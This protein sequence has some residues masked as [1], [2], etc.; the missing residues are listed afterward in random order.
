MGV[1]IKPKENKRELKEGETERLKNTVE[2]PETG[3]G[4]Q[5]QGKDMFSPSTPNLPPAGT[6]YNLAKDQSEMPAQYKNPPTAK[7]LGPMA[8]MHIGPDNKPFGKGKNSTSP[9]VLKQVSSNMPDLFKDVESIKNRV[10]N[11]ASDQREYH[12][13]GKPD[14]LTRAKDGKRVSTKNIDEGEFSK[15]NTM[16]PLKPIVTGPKGDQYY[17]ND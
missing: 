14:Y 8:K 11:F 9:T 12:S 1:K 4:L 2:L 10:D 5:T 17:V 6:R 13:F 15:V 3:Y 16:P 7:A